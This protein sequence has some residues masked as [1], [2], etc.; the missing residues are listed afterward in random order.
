MAFKNEFKNCPIVYIPWSGYPIER[1]QNF[2]RLLEIL[3]I[4]IDKLQP[5]TQPT[6][7]DKIILP[8]GSFCSIFTNEYR[9]TIDCVR[10]FAIKNRTPTA[11]KK[12]YYFYG[13][14]QVGEERL[15]QY[16][17]GKG[18]EIIRPELL[19]LDEQLNLMINAESFAS[20]AGSCAHNS[21]FLR[22]GTETI[23]IPRS[24]NAFTNYQP[25]IDQICSLNANYVDSTMSIFN[26]NHDSFCFIISEQLKRFFNDEFDGYEEDNFRSFLEYVKS[27][28]RRNRSISPKEKIG[29]GIT[30]TTFMEQIKR[31][32]DLIASYGMPPHWEQLRPLLTYQ[33][34]IHTKG[35]GDWS[36][37]DKISN[38]LD[39]K[40]DIQAIKID[41]S[42][43]KVYYSVYYNAQEGWSAV[44][45]NGEMA[46]TT[47]K[48]KPIYGMKVWL[49]E[50]GTKDFD[51]LYRMHKFDGEWT[52]WAKNGEIIYSHGQKLNSIQIKLEPK[53]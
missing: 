36:S 8:E 42:E 6:R 24:A 4:D 40:L 1:Q 35:W 13:R 16:F 5:I 11:S 33:T 21:L 23:F 37:E 29:Y 34:H 7:F 15:A 47:G 30:F 9:E 41:F 46:G 28:V 25:L 18:Y 52:P 26:I 38:P 44:V 50:A 39:Q 12:I 48:T 22:D 3:E 51:I 53:N 43:H 32:E 19:T 17:K 2:K 45:A 14:S 49:D 20:T 31:H 27:P 10:N